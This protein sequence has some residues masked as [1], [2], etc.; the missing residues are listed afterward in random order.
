MGTAIDYSVRIVLDGG[1]WEFVYR[2]EAVPQTL[3]DFK[4][5]VETVLKSGTYHNFVYY[6]PHRIH[7]V[8]ILHNER[9]VKLFN[10]K[11][12]GKE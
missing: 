2:P 9:E 1:E 12:W 8:E 10:P 6:P 5:H 4:R 11:D 7:E 3:R